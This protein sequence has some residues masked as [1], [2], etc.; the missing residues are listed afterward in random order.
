MNYFLFPFSV[1]FF[2]SLFVT[3]RKTVA[4]KRRRERSRR[5][6]ADTDTA[7]TRAEV[8][9]GSRQPATK[10]RQ[11]TAAA[12]IRA[13][14][15]RHKATAAAMMAGNNTTEHGTGA[16]QTGQHDRRHRRPDRRPNA[17]KQPRHAAHR[18]TKGMRTTPMDPYRPATATTKGR[19]G[20]NPTRPAEDQTDE[21]KTT[22]KDTRE[23]QRYPHDR[24]SPT[25]N[26]RQDNRP[27]DDGRR[28]GNKAQGTQPPPP[29]RAAG[30]QGRQANADQ[31]HHHKGQR[32]RSASPPR[33][34][35]TRTTAP[36]TAPPPSAVTPPGTRTKGKQER[37]DTD[38]TARSQR[39]GRANAQTTPTR[40]AP[41]Q[42]RQ[43]KRARGR[44]ADQ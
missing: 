23:K 21:Q 6:T 3:K 1:A 37:H 34:W 17:D 2:I 30:Q 20:N 15:Q 19:Q 42:Q 40:A 13:A 32:T 38:G 31:Q 16:I 12:I 44:Q 9:N 27:P 29:Q 39:A 11:T 8:R 28:N 22:Q 14:G 33:C 35:H 4:R 18:H 41:R 7:D 43:G 5:K 10:G 24:P 36:R 25:G 26:N